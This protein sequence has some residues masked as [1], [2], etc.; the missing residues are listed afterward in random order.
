MLGYNLIKGNTLIFLGFIKTDQRLKPRPLG[1][2]YSRRG[3]A[4]FNP[5]FS[6]AQYIAE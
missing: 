6:A 4:V 2:G 5:A 3:S 1:R